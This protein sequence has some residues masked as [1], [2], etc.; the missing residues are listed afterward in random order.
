MRSGAA[1]THTHNPHNTRTK[2][3]R[4]LDPQ[5]FR[6]RK[7]SG[8]VKIERNNETAASS[9]TF[10]VLEDY[11][12]TAYLPASVARIVGWEIMSV[13]RALHGIVVGTVRNG[14][15]ASEVREENA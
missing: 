4:V 6:E 13:R 11:R 3:F 14:V 12:C 9:M 2:W 1:D 5:H 8:K 7:T 10:V 15:T